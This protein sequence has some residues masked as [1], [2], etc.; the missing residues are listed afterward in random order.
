MVDVKSE[1][2]RLEALVA[3]LRGEVAA[4]RG[5]EEY[6]WQ[7]PVFCLMG[8][9][10]AAHGRQGWGEVIYS[11]MPGYMEVAGAKPWTYAAAL[12][13][14]GKVLALPAPEKLDVPAIEHK[15][16]DEVGL[17][18]AAAVSALKAG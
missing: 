1:L 3:W 8:R 13:R 2:Y 15:A 4:G 14:G 16:M 6:V 9:Y 12:E 10:S 5:D 7:D 17:K 18:S 11:D